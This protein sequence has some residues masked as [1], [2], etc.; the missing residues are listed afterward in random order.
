MLSW[1]MWLGYISRWNALQSRSPIPIQT[2]SDI[3][4]FVDTPN[5]AI[6]APHHHHAAQKCGR[7]DAYTQGDSDVIRSIP[8]CQLVSAMILRVKLLEMFVT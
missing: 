8:I 4:D 7:F 6:T 3:G 5:E 1:P 2:G